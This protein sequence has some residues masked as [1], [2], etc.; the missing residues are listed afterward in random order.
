M[1]ETFIEA[2]VRRMKKVDE[3]LSELSKTLVGLGYEVYKS[4]TGFHLILVKDKEKHVYVTFSDVPY[5]WDL[6]CNIDPSPKTGN[7]RLLKTGYSVEK[8]DDMELPWSVEQIVALMQ[9]IPKSLTYK[10]LIKYE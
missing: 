1:S 8:I 7:S 3:L 6:S 2:Y 5:H 9:P 10:H 4:G